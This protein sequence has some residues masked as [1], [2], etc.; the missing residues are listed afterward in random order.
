MGVQTVEEYGLT[1]PSKAVA[2]ETAVDVAQL[3]EVYSGLLYRVAYSVLRSQS[4]V[5]D[6]VQDVFV[7]VLE[8]RTQLSDIQQ[9]RV[10]LVRIAW[11]LALDRRRRIRPEQMDH[12]FASQLATKSVGPEEA[13]AE[14]RRIEAVLSEIE[15]LPRA[16]RNALL[17]ATVDELGTAEMAEVLKKSES[18][19]RALTFRARKRLRERL[20]KGG[21]L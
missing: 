21:V 1:I 11:N 20:K 15:R 3:V 4:D 17:L 12:E 10:W 14:A 18:A 13:L 7:R 6:V 2:V 16:E 5:E 8:R 19:I 9:M